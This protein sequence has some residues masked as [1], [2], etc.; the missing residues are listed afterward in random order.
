MLTNDTRPEEALRIAMD[1]EKAAI[2][3]YTRASQI[4]KETSTSKMFKQ[5][6][7]EEEVHLK[8]L[9]EEYDKFVMPEN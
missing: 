4:V 5:L 7:R 9:Q 2:E 6:A 1:R 3:F 8:R